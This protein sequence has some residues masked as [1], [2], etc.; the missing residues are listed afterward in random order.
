MPSN[1]RLVMV[2]ATSVE[3]ARKLARL[4]LDQH[5]AACVNLIPGLESHYWWQG[6]LEAAQEILLLIKSS[7]EKMDELTAVIS[8]NHAN[9]V[10]EIF[11][12]APEEI[13]PAYLHW[14]REN[15]AS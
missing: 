15:V 4:L 5:L 10:P 6:R 8:Q 7:A 1:P 11:S 12:L 3:E 14:W 9:E 13:A 2:T